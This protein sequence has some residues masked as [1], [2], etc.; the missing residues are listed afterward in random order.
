MVDTL[1]NVFMYNAIN[2]ADTETCC[3]GCWMIT[4]TIFILLSQEQ[5]K[6]CLC[7]IDTWFFAP[8]FECFI[9]K[10]RCVYIVVVEVDKLTVIYYFI[11][12]FCELFSIIELLK[13]VSN[14]CEWIPMCSHAFEIGC[15]VRGGDI[16]VLLI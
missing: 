10:S 3:S 9:E 6:I 2:H 11:A 12:L 14:W 1:L 8:G 16:S 13:E 15:E 4:E 5:D 7:F